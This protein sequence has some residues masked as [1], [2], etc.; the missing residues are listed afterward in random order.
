MSGAPGAAAPVQKVAYL[1]YCGLIDSA[2]VTKMAQTINS[3]VNDAS[4]GSIYLC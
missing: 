2:G 1:G 4:Y 3:V